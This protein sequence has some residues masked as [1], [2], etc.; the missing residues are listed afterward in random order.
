MYIYKKK[1]ERT[2]PLEYNDPSYRIV[3]LATRALF[4]KEERH[5]QELEILTFFRLQI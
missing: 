1:I 2:L 4:I 5:F 3:Y